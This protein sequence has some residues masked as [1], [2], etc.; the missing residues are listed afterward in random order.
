MR[1]PLATFDRHAGWFLAGALIVTALLCG[2]VGP[3]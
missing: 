2:A 3:S 1:G